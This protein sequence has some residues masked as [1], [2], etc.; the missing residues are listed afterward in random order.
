MNEKILINKDAA[1]MVG[2]SAKLEDGDLVQLKDLLLG[3]MLPSG[4]DAAWAL[5]SY[6]GK[7]MYS[8]QIKKH[9]QKQ[10]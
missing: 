1:D 9:Q 2:T 4:N 7:L 6:F 3:L 8:R 5:A 10:S